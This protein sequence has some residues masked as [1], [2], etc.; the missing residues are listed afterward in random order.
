MTNY[1]VT[2]YAGRQFEVSEEEL[3][4][5]VVNQLTAKSKG[6]AYYEAQQVKVNPALQ[7]ATYVASYTHNIG[8]NAGKC[9]KVSVHVKQI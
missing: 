3:Q 9:Q 5:F 7:E 4:T 8:I 1:I 2:G 6:L